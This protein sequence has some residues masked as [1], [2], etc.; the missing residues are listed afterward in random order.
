MTGQE[1][2][3]DLKFIGMSQVELSVDAGVS[4]TQVSK[5]VNNKAIVPLYI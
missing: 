5:W 4:Q 1:L 3:S 2:R